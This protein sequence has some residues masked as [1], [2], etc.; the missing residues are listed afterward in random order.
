MS[1][2]SWGGS[3]QAVASYDTAIALDS[4]DAEGLLYNRGCALQEN[5][6]LFDEAAASY[7]K[8]IALR[9]DYAEALCNRGAAL[10][11]GAW[12]DCRT[13]SELRPIAIAL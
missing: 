2:E 13:P 11:Q 5:L 1:T 7:D 10:L 9:S 12:V 4:D 6:K 8:A 3:T